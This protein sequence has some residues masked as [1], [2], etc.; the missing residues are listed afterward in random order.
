MCWRDVPRATTGVYSSARFTDAPHINQHLTA[1]RGWLVQYI[2]KYFGGRKVTPDIP[3]EGR[4][5]YEAVRAPYSSHV[6]LVS[7]AWVRSIVRN[8]LNLEPQTHAQHT[9][10]STVNTQELVA[11]DIDAFV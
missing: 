8:A 5:Y 9:R 3:R 6:V 11:D 4:N 10:I 7:H 2:E 1:V